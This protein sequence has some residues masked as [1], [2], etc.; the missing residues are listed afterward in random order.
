MI[1]SKSSSAEDPIDGIAL[2]EKFS[3]RINVVG[4]LLTVTIMRPGKPDVVSTTDMSGSGYDQGGQYMFFK[5]GVYNQN[6]SGLA[7]DYAQATFYNLEVSEK[8]VC[9][10]FQ[11]H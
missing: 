11:N 3:Y 5:A 1:G 8:H 2:D 4:N 10:F 7:D 9:Q 6:K